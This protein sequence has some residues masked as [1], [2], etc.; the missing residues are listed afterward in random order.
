MDSSKSKIKPNPREKANFISVLFWWWSLNLFK[1][2]Y[3]KVL[4]TDDLYDPLKED[5]STALGDR[6]EKRWKIELENAKKRKRSPYF[7]RAIFRT[8]LMEYF[9]LGLLQILNEFVIRLGTPLLLGGLLRYFRK[10]GGETYQTA[11]LYA[12]GICIATAIS[13]ITINQTIFKAFHIGAKVRIAA[14]SVVYRKALRLSQTALGDTAPGKVVNLVANDVNRFDLV[15]IFI[16]HMWSAPLSALIIA[17]FLYTEAGYSGLFGIAAVFVVVPIQSYTGKLSSKFRLQTAIKT[18][19]RVRLMD[20]IISGVQVIK[21]YAWEKPFCALVELAR[22]LELQVVSK[23]SSIRGIYMTFNLFTTRMAL[24]CTLVSMILLHNELTA[25]KVFVFS[26]YF[27]IL[28]QTMS[29]MFVRGFAEIAECLVVV[30][31]LQNFLMFDEF[32]SNNITISNKLSRSP[33]GSITSISRQTSIRASRQDLPYMD[34]DVNDENYIDDN[35]TNLRNGL[36]IVATDLLKNTAHLVN[37]KR[38]S[39]ADDLYAITMTNVVANWD[40]NHT[41]TILEGIQLSLEKGK[42]YAVIGMVGSGKSSLLS[43]ILGEMNIINGVVKCYGN[44]SYACQEAWV[45]GS[46]VR[47]NILFGQPYDRQRYQRIIKACALLRDFK[48]FPQ[49][50][51]TIVGDRGSSLSGGQKAR[52]NLARAMYKQADIYLLDDPL[53]AVDAHISKHLFEECLQRYLANKTRILATHQL[54]Y[55]KE[56][57]AIILMERGK[58]KMY[59]KYHDLLIDYPEYSSLLATDNEMGEDTSLDTNSIRRQFSSLSNRSHTPEASSACTDDEEENENVETLNNGLEGTS[60][61]VIKGSIFI[62]YFQ[63]GANLFLALMVLFL[64]IFTQCV[65]SLNDYFVPILVT[66][67][68]TLHYR[69]EKLNF[70]VENAEPKRI[71]DTYIYI[72]TGIVL[73]IFVIG[74][75]RSLIFYKM[76]M[77]CSQR[78][79]DMTFSAL[80]RTNMR[81]FDTNPSGR[82]LNRFSKDIGAIDELLPKA[83]LDAGQICMLMFGS[84]AVSCI[85]NPLFL[86][87]VIFLGTIFYWIRKV[88]LKTS[89]NIKRL[90]GMTRSP[91]FTHLNATLN[92]LSTIR[93][94]GAQEILK[95]EFDKFQDT[96]TSTVYMY[97]VTSTAFGFSLDVF[98]FIFTSLVTFSFLLLNTSFSGGEVGLA[99]TQVM[100]M[101]GMIQWGM[102]QSAE[103]ANQMMSVERV[104]EY[105]QLPPETNLRNKGK[106]YKKTDK[107]I[108]NELPQSAPKNWPS[109]GCIRFKNV[110]MKYT[111][112]DPPIL[113]NLNFLVLPREKV[114]IVG[115]TGAG[116]SSLISALFRLAKVEGVIEI[117][118]IDTGSIFLEDLRCNISIIPQDPVLFSGTLR[119]NLDPFNEFSDN[120]VWEALEEVELKEAII[121]NGNGLELRVLDRGS[122][123]SVGQRQLICLSRAIL[124]NNRILMLDEATAN[125]DPQTD[126]LIQHT[127]RKKFAFC[128]V[129]TVAHRLNT[130][131]DSDKVLVMDKGRMAEYDHPHI[132]LQNKYSQFTSLVKETGRA[133]SDQLIKMAKQSYINKYGEQTL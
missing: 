116:K 112:E 29:G 54:Q 106:F 44:V 23:S 15:S 17:Y 81:F 74:I 24:Y 37:D 65:A 105:T 102:R 110:Y 53:S 78:L 107:Q 2:G 90:E 7:L 10:G 22:K 18:D 67:E 61:G 93:A 113:K 43:T 34:D 39:T 27:N 86:I 100:A 32:R 28:A 50:D 117:D 49:G 5:S 66:V 3:K 21:M 68:E 97:I 33:N 14:C 38:V 128:T 76:C 114:G 45:F 30:R 55:I 120:I 122:N 124:R 98:C 63:D 82:I 25:E 48:Q 80:I 92:G 83:L 91:V 85:V 20:E 9:L 121:G 19:E 60:R 125:V 84:L 77:L 131:M 58:F 62:R 35:G 69:N 57:D 94:Y 1:V 96:H 36:V 118:N 70:T 73:G 133:M 11:L 4:E 119:R 72:Y 12:S 75:T 40:S 59:E 132:L 126:A 103:V 8:F 87:P 127:I 46:T 64:I 6:L 101:T 95:K 41:D 42:L 130:I 129:L 99:I 109:Q 89:K 47:Q 115:R 16:H 123:F 51:L 111:D 26:S 104:L 71:N 88:Y 56:V 52:I 108:I 13:V 79:Y 31:R